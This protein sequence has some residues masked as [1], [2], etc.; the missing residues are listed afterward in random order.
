MICYSDFT[1]KLVYL[2]G[3]STL[4]LAM[5]QREGV[6]LRIFL[7]TIKFLVGFMESFPPRKSVL[8]RE[9]FELKRARFHLKN[10]EEAHNTVNETSRKCKHPYGGRIPSI[11]CKALLIQNSCFFMCIYNQAQGEMLLRHLKSFQISLKHLWHP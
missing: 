4:K 2:F 1:R 11:R 8:K 10:Y 5:V 9:N 6:V 7:P 3:F